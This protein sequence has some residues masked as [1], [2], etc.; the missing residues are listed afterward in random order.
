MDFSQWLGQLDIGRLLELL[1]VAT[2]GL[3]CI[4]FHEVSHGYA[5]FL[6]GDNTA[7]NA[8][9]L[10]FNPLRHIDIMGLIC[11]ALAHFGWAKPVP[12]NPGNFRN[13]RRGM[14]ITALAGPL[15]NFLLAGI[16]LT[17]YAAF[18]W[19]E[20]VYAWSGYLLYIP[21]FFWYGGV[22]SI[23]LGIFNLFPIPPLDGSKVVLSFLPEKWYWKILRFERYGFI[24]LA[25][26]LFT[27]L[28]DGPL[29]FLREGLLNVLLR[30]CS[31]P[32]Y[33]LNRVVLGV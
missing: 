1:V 24:L 7:K 3:I 23:T 9:R 10:T 11:M 5:A 25:V 21:M 15:S 26:L 28:L 22:L 27:G 17:L 14:V 30:L 2:A 4:M 19:L 12:I 32:I 31:W 8:G 33:V 20:Q 18:W 13:P 29:S 16:F 6:M